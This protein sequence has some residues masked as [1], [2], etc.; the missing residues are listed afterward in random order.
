MD[1]LYPVE[2][3]FI[4]PELS[5]TMQPDGTWSLT[6]KLIYWSATTKRRYVVP[7]GFNTDFAST[8]R[9]PVVYLLTGNTA[10]QAA[11]LHDYLYR[12]GMESRTVSDRL[13]REAMAA[14]GVPAWRRTMMWL[15][16][17]LFGRGAYVRTAP[18]GNVAPPDAPAS[19]RQG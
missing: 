6:R 16:V 13:F 11:V 8:P 7:R 14:T 1:E 10:H 15:G 19:D 4:G 12:T 18:A 3:G 9:L 17:R 2:S 5:A